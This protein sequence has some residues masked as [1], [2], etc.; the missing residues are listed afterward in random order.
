[1]HN[2]VHNMCVDTCKTCVGHLRRHVDDQMY[3]YVADKY[4]EVSVGAM[5]SGSREGP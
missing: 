5:V 4:I 1:M 3:E 2:H